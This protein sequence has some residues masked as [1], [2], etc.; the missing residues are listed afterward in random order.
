MTPNPVAPAM[1]SVGLEEQKHS[2]AVAEAAMATAQAVQLTRPFRAGWDR[3]RQAAIL[4]QTAFRGYLVSIKDQIF[5]YSS[6]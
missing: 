4:I 1:D 6:I 2:L 3:H 5:H